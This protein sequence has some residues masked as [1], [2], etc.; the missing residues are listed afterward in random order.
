MTEVTSPFSCSAIESWYWKVTTRELTFNEKSTYYCL[1]YNDGAC[2]FP[3]QVIIHAQKLVGKRIFTLEQHKYE[4]QKLVNYLKTRNDTEVKINA[5]QNDRILLH[6]ERVESALDLRPGDHIERPTSF[7]KVLYHHM[8]VIEKPSNDSKCK[9]IHFGEPSSLK[10]SVQEEEVDIFKEGENVFCIKYPE[11]CEPDQG[12][13]LLR[14]LVEVS[15]GAVLVQCMMVK[16]FAFLRGN[17]AS[18]Y[19]NYAFRTSTL[20]SRDITLCILSLFRCNANSTIM[21]KCINF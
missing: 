7:V 14:R 9:V 13:E 19:V 2:I 6:R 5:L 18:S 3:E 1:N 21:Q 15:L 16:R 8:M 11:R 17:L 10:L 20:F 12:I 4:R